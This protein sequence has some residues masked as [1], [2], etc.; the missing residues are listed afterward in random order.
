MDDVQQR[1]R[2]RLQEELRRH[3]ASPLLADPEVFAAVDDLLRRSAAVDRPGALLLPEVLGAPDAWRL[4]TALRYR[5]HRQSLAGRLII[6]VKRHVLMPAFRWLFEFSRDNF[7]RQE[8]V[9]QMLFACVQEL[10]IE[11]ARLRAD[12]QRLAPKP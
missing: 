3:G 11:N 9:N 10:A 8:R 4:E 7:A 2:T 1:V 12:L 6:G 5:T